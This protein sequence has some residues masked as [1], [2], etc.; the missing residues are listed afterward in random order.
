MSTLLEIGGDLNALAELI[1]EQPGGE[2]SP[3][4]EAALDEMFRETGESLNAKVDGYCALIRSLIL[5]A[6]ARADEA[7]RLVTLA[8]SDNAKAKRLKERLLFFMAL[9]GEKHLSTE[10]YEITRCNNG[11]KRGVMLA[12][13][14]D[15]LPE[16]FQ[17]VKIEP[18]V[19]TIRAALE[20][21]DVVPGCSLKP[22]GEHVT[23]R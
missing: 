2:L 16:Q 3:E 10:R 1:A 22:R 21:G 8:E 13:D 19:D 4:V 6:E 7:K 20:S 18:D 14:A 17:R 12:C 23:I 5:T 11:G 15:Q 9:R